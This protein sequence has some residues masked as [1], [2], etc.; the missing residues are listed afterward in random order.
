[1][2]GYIYRLA[3]GCPPERVPS[4][5]EI[6]FSADGPFTLATTRE[7]VAFCSWAGSLPPGFPQTRNL[8]A[9]GSADDSEALSK[10]LAL[11]AVV[12]GGPPPAVSE[13]FADL[14]GYVG[15]GEEGETVSILQ[16]THR[17]PPALPPPHRTQGP[18]PRA[19]SR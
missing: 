8:A 6:A 1:V 7:W 4:L 14:R 18:R 13:A 5:A 15:V 2:G 10:E 16:S 19:E 12:H 11:V 9:E 17:C 3:L